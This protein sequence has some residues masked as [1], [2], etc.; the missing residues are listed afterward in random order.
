MELVDAQQ[1]VSKKL[2]AANET[3]CNLQQTVLRTQVANQLLEERLA[4]LDRQNAALTFRAID[5]WIA[6]M[7]YETSVQTGISR[8]RRSTL[9]SL[10]P[11]CH[12]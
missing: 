3:M 4:N 6:L 5:Y 12:S 7:L 11:F 10:S 1:V 2:V 8:S 9:C